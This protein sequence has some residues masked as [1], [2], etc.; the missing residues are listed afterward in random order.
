MP[1]H[2]I[3]GVIAAPGRGLWRSGNGGGVKP[4]PSVWYICA[5]AETDALRAGSLVGRFLI[6]ACMTGYGMFRR[7]EIVALLEMVRD[8][9]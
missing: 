6:F 5:P 8:R 7:S 3:P 4:K 2:M 1:G 9:R